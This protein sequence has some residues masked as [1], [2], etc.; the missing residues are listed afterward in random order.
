MRR[1]QLTFRI[2]LLSVFVLLIGCIIIGRLYQLQ[3]HSSYVYVDKAERQYVH[4][5][6]DLY[7]RGSIFF[8]TRDGNKLSAAAVRSG[9]V[10]AVNPEMITDA[11]DVCE[12]ILNGVLK[13]QHYLNEHMLN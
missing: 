13:E 3:I 1:K 2:R 7:D 9:Y 10:L 8:E 12:K 6:A 4:T 11:N 5:A